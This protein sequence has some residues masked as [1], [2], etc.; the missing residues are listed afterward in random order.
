MMRPVPQV[1]SSYQYGES[2]I[3]QRAHLVFLN[4]GVTSMSLGC[5]LA[6]ATGVQR[7]SRRTR[8]PLSVRFLCY[9]FLQVAA[10]V[11]KRLIRNQ[12][13]L[14]RYIQLD[15]YQIIRVRL[16]TKSH[17]YILFFKL[18]A[19]AELHRERRPLWYPT[20][21]GS[22]DRQETCYLCLQLSIVEIV[23]QP[24]GQVARKRETQ[25]L[26]QEARMPDGVVR[27]FHI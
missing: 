6:P 4:E 21:D 15:R 11:H 23:A 18:V 24:R 25:Q 7:S 22:N 19:T 13:R 12:K 20:I 2:R 17:S 16:E 10:V 3:E 1:H 14:V 5:F 26:E 9:I 8:S 27:S